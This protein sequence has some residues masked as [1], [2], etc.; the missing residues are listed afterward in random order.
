MKNIVITSFKTIDKLTASG[1]IPAV[2]ETLYRDLIN[3]RDKGFF[4]ATIMCGL[5]EG[6]QWTV[7]FGND[8]GGNE[9]LLEVATNFI[10]LTTGEF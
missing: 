5:R 4:A 3:L 7:F 8:C 2:K 9:D 10:K 1:M 6:E